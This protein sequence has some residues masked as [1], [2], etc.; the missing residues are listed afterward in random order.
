M[1]SLLEA[2]IEEAAGAVV[3]ILTRLD[4]RDSRKQLN[5]EEAKAP[6]IVKMG[7]SRTV[8]A[9]HFRRRDEGDGQEVKSKPHILRLLGI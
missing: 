2:A 8:A 9:G 1:L 5:P 7:Q 4:L 3:A 6:A